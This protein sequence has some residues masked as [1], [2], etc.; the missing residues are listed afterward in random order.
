MIL[1]PLARLEANAANVNSP[2]IEL[3]VRSTSES[4]F[5]LVGPAQAVLGVATVFA[6]GGAA[7]TVAGLTSA[8]AQPAFKQIE[9]A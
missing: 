6:T 1:V 4:K 5:N 3:L 2:K 9:L 7:S 8:L